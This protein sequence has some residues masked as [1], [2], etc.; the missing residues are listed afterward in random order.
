M[1]KYLL[2]LLG[3][4][5]SQ[6]AGY[7][8]APA[9]LWQKAAAFYEQ[10][11]YDSAA[12]YFEQIAAHHPDNPEL[13]YNL[14]N[15]YY[16]LNRI[17]LSVLNFRRALRLRPEF[18]E[19]KDNLDLAEG[20]IANRIPN[21]GDIFFIKWWHLATRADRASLWAILSFVLFSVFIL[22][23]ISSFF[24]RRNAVRVPP[25]LSGVVAVVC[26]FFLILAFFAARNSADRSEAVVMIGDSPL[27]HADGK[28]KPIVLLPEGTTVQIIAESGSWLEVQ[29]TDGRR[30]MLM[31]TVVERI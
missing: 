27:M 2:V 18:K 16:R 22:I 29:L 1:K 4:I 23:V 17:A 24:S 12:G 31:Q 11:Q 25:Q 6:S 26:L 30:G 19:A 13:Y 14:G 21:A 10:K 3:L 5:C 15:T 9:E 7:C 20:R 8:A 28:G